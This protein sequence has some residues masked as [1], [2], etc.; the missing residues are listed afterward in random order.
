M[1]L[2][3]ADTFNLISVFK[4]AGVLI[5]P[6]LLCSVTAVFIVC[7]RAYAL[8]KAAVIPQ[9]L[10]DAVVEG[11]PLMGGKHT[12]LA[13]IVDFAERHKNDEGAVKAFAR[14][15]LNRMERG[16]PYLDVIYAAAPLIGLTG[17]V[18]GLL[19]VFSQIS[20][21]T[22]LPDPVAFT[23]GVAL[24]LSATVIGLC[25]A[26]PSLVGSGYLQRKIENYAAQLDVLLERILQRSR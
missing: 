26:I 24:A 25:I 21:D 10:V 1:L 6:L 16:I 2:A 17:T 5:W 9:D 13:R 19:Q 14:L 18:V 11:R 4:G 7:E 22:G 23:K 8:R 3:A 20:P 15:Q 12:V